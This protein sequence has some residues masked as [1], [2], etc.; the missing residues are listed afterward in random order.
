MTNI[1]KN[2]GSEALLTRNNDP[3]K[4]TK[5]MRNKYG[6][7]LNVFNDRKYKFCKQSH[8]VMQYIM[9]HSERKNADERCIQAVKVPHE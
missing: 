4:L 1:N 3:L 5:L 9:Y 2:V 8:I 7:K 6:P